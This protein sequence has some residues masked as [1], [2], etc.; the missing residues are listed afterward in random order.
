MLTT[1]LLNIENMQITI[2]VFQD[3]S[4][5]LD[6]FSLNWQ[7]SNVIFSLLINFICSSLAIFLCRINVPV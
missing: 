7:V 5:S 3:L 2:L 4:E 6:S 1:G